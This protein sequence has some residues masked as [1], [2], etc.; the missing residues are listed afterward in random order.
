MD[1]EVLILSNTQPCREDTIR[2]IVFGDGGPSKAFFIPQERWK[3]RGGDAVNILE[4]PEF[5]Q[6]A[7][8]LRGYRNLDD[9]CLITQG[10]KPFQVGKGSPSQTREIVESKP[11]VASEKKNKTFRPLLR[12]S[13]IQRYQIL[14]NDD[15]WI[16]F[17]DW[18]AEPRYSAN[19]DA[20]EKI[21][22]RQTGDSIVAT[23][24]DKRFIVR[25]NLYTIIPREKKTNLRY[26][27]G[28]L[29][30]RLLNWFYQKAVNPE[31][32]EALAQVKRG[33]LAKLPVAP[34]ENSGGK[35]LVD[36]VERML[37]VRKKDPSADTS[38]LEREIDQRVYAL[39]GLTADEI[40]IVEEASK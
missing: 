16:S 38:A 21:V 4:K 27:L 20:P 8:K 18:L 32:G 14:W 36:L 13:L 35:K 11:F 3:L 40:K 2:V 25:D 19:Y 17:G 6:L 26:I 22:V 28:I 12:G 39:Y 24:D 37:S 29:N 30:S 7:D 9:V 5:T 31:E 33:H 34:G 23:L 15:Y 1:N 10:A